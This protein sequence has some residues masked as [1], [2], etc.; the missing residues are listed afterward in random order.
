MK[1]IY[2]FIDPILSYIKN[3]TSICKY[4]NKSK[5]IQKY[6]AELMLKLIAQVLE[7]GI[8]WRSL[9]TFYS[10]N[11]EKPKWITVYKFYNQLINRKI[12]LNTY[13]Q[14]LKKYFVKG[15]N[16]KL[17]YRYTDTSFIY[18][19]NGGESVKYNKFFGR[20]KCCKLSLITDKYGVPFN[21]SIYNGNINDSAI[22]LDQLNSKNIIDIEENNGKKNYFFA[23]SGYDSSKIRSKLKE[24]N[25]IPIIPTNKR[26][27]KDINKII[28]LTKEEQKKYKKRIKIEHVF[29]QLKTERKILTRYDK[30]NNVFLNFIY[31]H[32]IKKLNV[33]Q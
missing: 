5:K 29:G 15:K 27:T 16:N 19:R 31:L 18:S 24:L 28:K 11:K 32:L 13:A 12:I 14:M 8:S 17:N 1:N 21:I 33:M 9:D 20:K 6:P 25:L 10:K 23:D 22:L 7:T 2:K 26:N 4:Y 3:N 30:N